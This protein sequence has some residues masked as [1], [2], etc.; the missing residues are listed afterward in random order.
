MS[1]HCNI[2]IIGFD[3]QVTKEVKKCIDS[4][5][6]DLRI[7]HIQVNKQF[8]APFSQK[9]DEE[10]DIIVLN[11][12]GFSTPLEHIISI[13][14]TRYPLTEIV[15]INFTQDYDLALK[16]FRAGVRDIIRYPFQGDEFLEALERS[17]SYR[18]LYQKSQSLS[19]I[20]SLLNQFGDFKKFTSSFD[21]MTKFDDFVSQKFSAHPFL[22]ISYNKAVI[23][24]G[25]IDN[26][27]R[28]LWNKGL[29]NENYE[30]D[31]VAKLLQS[32]DVEIFTN[33]DRSYFEANLGEWTYYIIAL[34]D[35]D[36]SQYIGL[37]KILNE[38]KT[39]Y[40]SKI[41]GHIC[42]MVQNGHQQLLL[43]KA[44]EDLTLLVHNDDVTGLYNQRKLQA[45]LETLINNYHLQRDIFSVVFIDIDHFKSVNDGHGHLIG[46]QLLVEIAQVLRACLRDEDF[47]YRYGGDEFVVILPHANLDD[48]KIVGERILTEIK[49]HQ[50]ISSK[51]KN[52][53]MSASV[54]V[55]EFPRD[56]ANKDD[57][58]NIADSMMYKAKN[59]GRGKVVTTR[60]MFTSEKENI[61]SV[62]KE[63]NVADEKSSTPKKI[64]IK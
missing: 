32:C 47:I 13:L 57:I 15:L 48:A 4:C 54:G 61:K 24:H 18:A 37:F 25:S 7:E 52:L 20:L 6:L 43:A 9:I 49:A 5:Y 33:T 38:K 17:Q 64:G 39:D 50:F 2:S 27:F 11:A 30:R 34:G 41:V 19:D 60:E 55:A 28:T 51:R 36:N 42:R 62:V 29:F 8:D 46:S 58:L 63:S 45:D 53:S 12:K 10:F 22:I 56:A 26:R 23:N 35:Y 1:Q 40:F 16:A 14:K 44:K 31:E 59:A 3:S 21:L